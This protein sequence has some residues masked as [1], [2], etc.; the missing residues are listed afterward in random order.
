MAGQSAHHCADGAPPS[1]FGTWSQSRKTLRDTGGNPE[2]VPG[3]VI[4][5]PGVRDLYVAGGWHAPPKYCS[6][7][8]GDRPMRRPVNDPTTTRQRGIFVIA[9]V[10]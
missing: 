10:V 7:M 8:P 9:Q 5:T 4:L 6:S 3:Y 2:R 1:Y